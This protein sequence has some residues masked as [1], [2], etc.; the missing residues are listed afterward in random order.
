MWCANIY[1]DHRQEWFFSL[2]LRSYMVAAADDE[3]FF[4]GEERK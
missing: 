2:R 1:D 4:F 3:E